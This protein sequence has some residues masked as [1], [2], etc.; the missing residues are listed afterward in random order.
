METCFSSNI[1]PPDQLAQPAWWFIFQ[2][3]KILLQ[4]I[5]N[6]SRIPQFSNIELFNF[7]I[8]RQLYLG[9]YSNNNCFTAQ[10][11]Q[12]DTAILP[13]GM[14]FQSIR[15][16]H[17]ILV[18]DELFSII[19]RARQLLHWDKSTLFCGYCGRSTQVSTKERAKNCLNCKTLFFPPI[20]PVILALIWRGD[21][22]LLARSPHFMLGM[23]SVLAG[24]VEPGETIE[25]TAIREVRE[26]VGVKVKNLQYFGSQPWPFPSSLMLGFIA[27]YESGDIQIDKSEIEDA[28]W[29]SINKLPE[30]PQPISLS[31]RMID[32]YVKT[33][34]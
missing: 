22:I 7:N 27:E 33:K 19:A 6:N 5:A 24:F 9:M 12:A 15:Q 34:F 28:Q 16:P 26:E 20:S 32:A 10:I 3:E 11:H 30:L 23:Y 17:T 8:E 18:N 4:N 2:D 21:E 13:D 1:T 29:F 31:R 14:S 25:H